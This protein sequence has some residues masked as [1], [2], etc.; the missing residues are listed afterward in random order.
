MGLFYIKFLK[1]PQLA[2][3]KGPSGSFT[4]TT[5]FTITSDLG[6][7]YFPDSID[8]KVTLVSG[9]ATLLKKTISWTNGSQ[10]VRCDMPL[11]NSKVPSTGLSGLVLSLSPIS[12]DVD[13]QGLADGL[14]ELS[15]IYPDPSARVISASSSQTKLKGKNLFA[16]NHLVERRLKL[17]TTDEA[18][19]VWE[20]TGENIAGHIW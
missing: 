13:E 10:F 6:D 19:Y 12:T 2:P 18:L 7:I 4:L 14:D 3:L 1:P 11:Q 16:A 15:R 20:E 5:V 17:R 9:N 8:I